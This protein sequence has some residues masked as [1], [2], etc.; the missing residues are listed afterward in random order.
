LCHCFF[1]PH[2]VV[3]PLLLLVQACECLYFSQHV[4]T[5]VMISIVSL[6]I[7]PIGLLIILSYILGDNKTLGEND[8]DG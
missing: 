1:E 3:V 5:L 7:L 6:E 8:Y 4:Y 2:L